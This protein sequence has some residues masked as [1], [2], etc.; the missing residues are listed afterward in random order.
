[1]IHKTSSGDLFYQRNKNVLVETFPKHDLFAWYN[2]SNAYS[3]YDA[4]GTLVTTN[5]SAIAS[6]KDLSGNRNHLNSNGDSSSCPTYVVNTLNGYPIANFALNKSALSWTNTC[7]PLSFYMVF[8]ITTT[9][10]SLRR[11]FAFVYGSS[12]TLGYLGCNGSLLVCYLGTNIVSTPINLNN[13]YIVGLSLNGCNNSFMSLNNQ[14]MDIDFVWTSYFLSSYL[15]VNYAD[16]YYTSMH[17]AELLQFNTKH[18]LIENEKI[19]NYLNAK[20][21]I[22]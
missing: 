4:T 20:Y 11:F 6:F 1:M 3:G 14:I 2:T 9:T 18:S 5:G 19:V 13:Y 16:S 10:T 8:K 7:L 21:N 22:F 17:L 15:S 12:S